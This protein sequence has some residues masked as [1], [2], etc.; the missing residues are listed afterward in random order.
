MYCTVLTIITVAVVNKCGDI[1]CNVRLVN[2]LPVQTIYFIMTFQSMLHQRVEQ[3]TELKNKILL[4]FQ[5]GCGCGFY[6]T[7]HCSSAFYILAKEKGKL[8][9]QFI[10]QVIKSIR[11]YCGCK[12]PGHPSLCLPVKKFCRHYF[13][14]KHYG[15]RHRCHY[16]Y[17]FLNKKILNVIVMTAVF[18]S[19]IL[20][21]V[22]TISYFTTPIMDLM[23]IRDTY[24]YT[25]KNK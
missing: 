9:T 4:T 16:S 2:L 22:M 23:K 15:N 19:V 25:K 8:G 20:E 17:A 10:Y 13:P 6:R 18:T 12:Y 7:G 21:R 5:A 3:C 24:I 14:Q 11:S 1:D